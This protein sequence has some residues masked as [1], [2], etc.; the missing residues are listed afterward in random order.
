MELK[1]VKIFFVF[2]IG[3]I[4]FFSIHS[5]SLHTYNWLRIFDNVA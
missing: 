2:S 1:F 5:R 3:L 4:F